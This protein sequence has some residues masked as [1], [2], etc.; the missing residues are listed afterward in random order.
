[1]VVKTVARY[2]SLTGALIVGIGDGVLEGAKE[3]GG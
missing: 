2:S 3:G 1:V